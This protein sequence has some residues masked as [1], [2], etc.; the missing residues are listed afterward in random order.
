[1]H[2]GNTDT[3]FLK[4]LLQNISQIC[5]DFERKK[6]ISEIWNKVIRKKLILSMMKSRGNYIRRNLLIDKYHLVLLGWQN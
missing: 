6:Q 2:E 5:Y 3:L 1:M 4:L